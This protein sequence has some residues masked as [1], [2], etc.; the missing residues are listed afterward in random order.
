[1]YYVPCFFHFIQPTLHSHKHAGDFRRASWCPPEERTVGSPPSLAR[2]ASELSPVLCCFSPCSRTHVFAC[3]C[4][5]ICGTVSG[6]L[7]LPTAPSLHTRC[8]EQHPQ[9]RVLKAAGVARSALSLHLLLSPRGLK[10]AGSSVRARESKTDSFTCP[11]IG[12]RRPKVGRLR[13]KG[14]RWPLQAASWLSFPWSPGS[15][16]PKG[17]DRKQPQRTTLSS[18]GWLQLAPHRALGGSPRRTG[19]GAQAGSGPRL[20]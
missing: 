10:S 16:G 6:D 12:G 20:L 3:V 15:Q 9:V 2:W 18:L 19:Q 14:L 11:E 13:A 4:Q 1:M 5:R 7:L 8:R 17:I